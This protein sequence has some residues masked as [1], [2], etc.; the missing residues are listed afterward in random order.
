MA[1]SSIDVY[2]D[3]IIQVAEGLKLLAS[4]TSDIQHDK[5][6]LKEGDVVCLF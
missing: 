5:S 4:V 3:F 1:L 2:S 6:N